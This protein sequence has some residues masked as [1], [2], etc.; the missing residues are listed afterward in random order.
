MNF[1]TRQACMDSVTIAPSRQF[2][3]ANTAATKLTVAAVPNFDFA[4][5]EYRALHERSRATAF[6]NAGWLAA[7]HQVVAPAV[8]AEPM[9]MAVRDASDG[10]LMLVLPFARHRLH[11]LK[12]L[13]FADFGLCDYLGA[14]YDPADV[15]LLLADDSLPKRVADALPHHDVLQ[16]T[17]LSGS[18]PLLEYV[19]P[20]MQRAR[21]RVSAYPARLNGDWTAWRNTNIDQSFRRYLDMKRR[22]L[23]RTGTPHF[24]RL[25]D[26]DAI[27]CA[28]EALRRY[29]SERF[30]AL[31]VPDL[32][33]SDA[34]FEFYKRMAIDGARD[35]FARTHCLYLSGEPVAITFGV[36]QR[37][38]YALLLVGLDVARHSRLSPG[39]LAIED[40]L[41][42][43]LEAGDSTYDFTIGDHPYKLQFG[44][45]PTSLYEWHQART[46]R[47]H[48]AVLGITLVREVKRTLKPLMKRAK[49]RLS[50][51]APAAG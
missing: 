30:R 38:V 40:T 3:R 13:R 12:F 37:G 24:R 11:G 10:R 5:A 2:V 46:L 23:K 32:L 22:R 51:S 35:G 14:I 31:G 8:R 21:M 15:P 27:A 9:T 50:K 20:D 36:V 7:L 39:L 34:V 18:D 47:G 33:D 45:Q 42:E 4:N 43:S 6:Q 48:A 29:R 25:C 41:R 49:E 16:F 26:P 19:F 44:G 1:I 17:K 28:L